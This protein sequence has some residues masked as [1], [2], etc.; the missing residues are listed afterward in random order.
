[1]SDQQQPS[2]RVD[3]IVRDIE[4]ELKR[5][6]TYVNN[7][8]VP[9]VREASTTALRSAAD[10]LRKAADYLEKKKAS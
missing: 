9:E 2:S 7:Q 3:E 4:R 6:V 5:V 10:Q 8:V 1:M